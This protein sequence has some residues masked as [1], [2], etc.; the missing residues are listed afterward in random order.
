MSEVKCS[1]ELRFEIAKEYP[2][3]PSTASISRWF[4]TSLT[5]NSEELTADEAPEPFILICRIKTPHYR[6]DRR[7]AAMWCA[8]LPQGYK[9]PVRFYTT[10]VRLL[11]L[12]VRGRVYCKALLCGM[13][14]NG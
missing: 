10:P 2:N 11:R 14:F 1:R 7:M 9:K 13:P 3:M 8:E 12:Y 6:E 4:K 5:Q